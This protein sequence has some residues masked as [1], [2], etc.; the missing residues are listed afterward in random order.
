MS[1]LHHVE[2]GPN[3]LNKIAITKE[4]K[5]RIDKWDG[6]KLKSFFS[7][8][9]RNNQWGEDR[10]T[11]WEQIFTT[12]TSDRTLIPRIYKELKSLN[13]KK[14]KKKK[15]KKRKRKKKKP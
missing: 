2:L 5:P 14:K 7:S 12:C 15:R 4:S 3:F 1:Y 9:E 10:G 13:T 8:K 6:L 11:E